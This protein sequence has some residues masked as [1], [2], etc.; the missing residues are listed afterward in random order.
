MR[1]GF[2]VC[3]TGAQCIKMHIVNTFLSSLS[4]SHFE[5]RELHFNPIRPGGGGWGDGK[6]P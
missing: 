5:W 2:P 3:V 6:F 4:A 1:R